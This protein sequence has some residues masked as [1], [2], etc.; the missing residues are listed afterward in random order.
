MLI[1]DIK[2][3]NMAL[4][5]REE[6]VR[7]PLIQIPPEEGFGYKGVV[8]VD[9]VTGH[10]QCHVCGEL[11]SDLSNHVRK[12]KISSREYK[13]K[14]DLNYSTALKSEQFLQNQSHRMS[15]LHKLL[16]TDMTT[17]QISE[18]ARKRGRLGAAANRKIAKERR[19]KKLEY[20]YTLEMKN[21]FGTCPAQIEERFTRIVENLG[22][23]P[24]FDELKEIDH[25]LLSVLFRRFKSYSNAL[26][27]FGHSPKKKKGLTTYGIKAITLAIKEFVKKNKRLPTPRDT[28]TSFLPDYDTLVKYFGSWEAVKNV[29]ML[30]LKRYAPRFVHLYDSRMRLK[31]PNPSFI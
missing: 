5:P 26:V 18:I 9:D 25:S 1:V 13:E 7:E 31:S 16:Y 23:A 6:K 17:E 21:R 11:F 14:F 28:K 8:L 12:H 29:A 20:R 30:S 27:Y 3:T 15:Y 10:L 24:T 4:K 2:D 22:R 19:K